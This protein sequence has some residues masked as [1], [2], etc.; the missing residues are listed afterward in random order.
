M[1]V[2]GDQ[3]TEVLLRPMTTS[4][5]VAGFI[6]RERFSP[7]RV[8]PKWDSVTDGKVVAAEKQPDGTVPRERVMTL[9]DV[10]TSFFKL[11]SLPLAIQFGGILRN[12]VI[13]R[14][15]AN[16]WIEIKNHKKVNGKL[17]NAVG[18]QL[19]ITD[20][21]QRASYEKALLNPESRESNE[22]KDLAYTK[23][24]QD[25]VSFMKWRNRKVTLGIINDE[26]IIKNSKYKGRRQKHQESATAGE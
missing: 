12:D 9:A 2:N 26:E 8:M 6:S 7:M 1:F 21:R 17:K 4:E 13:R 15:P 10:V 5:E 19:M 18:Y 20:T 11:E 25:Y 14:V 22:L 23:Q 16:A 3:L 24:Q